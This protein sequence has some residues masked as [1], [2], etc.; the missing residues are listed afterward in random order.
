M[1]P[2]IGIAKSTAKTMA[3]LEL[4]A[5]PSKSI[6]T[7]S[8]TPIPTPSPPQPYCTKIGNRA[9]QTKPKWH[10]C[11]CG[12]QIYMPKCNDSMMVA[13]DLDWPQHPPRPLLLSLGHQYLPP[14]PCNHITQKLDTEQSRTNQN[15]TSA[16]MVLSFTCQCAMTLRWQ[17]TLNLRSSHPTTLYDALTTK[18][19]DKIY[20][21]EINLLLFMLMECFPIRPSY[22]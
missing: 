9:K 3:D 2:H 14:A 18:R 15:G 10:Q 19:K 13:V 16:I 6:A 5:V 12:T 7:V 8:W 17:P 1:A 11:H 21:T 20:T 4:A 22:L